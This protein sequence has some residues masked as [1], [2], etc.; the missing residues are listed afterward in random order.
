MKENLYLVE[1]RLARGNVDLV[2]LNP[3]TYQEHGRYELRHDHKGGYNVTAPNGTKW[4]RDNLVAAENSC[5]EHFKS[6]AN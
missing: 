6:L 1:R 4:N 3:D 2:L 5:V